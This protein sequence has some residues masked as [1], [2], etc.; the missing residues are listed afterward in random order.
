[1]ASQGLTGSRI[2]E[3]RLMRGIR[4]AELAREI[5]ISASYLNLIEH[6]RRRIGGKLLLDIAETLGVAP[7]MLIQGAEAALVAS[8]REAGDVAGLSSTEADRVEDFAGRFPGWAEALSTAHRRIAA[9][10][11]TIETLSDRM[12]HDPQLAASLYELLSTAAAIRS[13]AAILA[14]TKD[15]DQSQQERFHENM[16]QDSAR[17]SDS[18]KRLVQFLDA[19]PT[20]TIASSPTEEVETFLSANEYSF[21]ELEA[22]NI[23]IDALLETSERNMSTDAQKMTRAVLRRMVQDSKTLPTAKLRKAVIETGIDPMRLA[24]SL[25]VPLPL[26]LRRLANVPEYGLGLVVCDRSGS[27]IFRKP[28]EGF[29]IP[30]FGAACPLW[31]LFQALAM[32]GHILAREMTQLGRDSAVFDVFAM[33]EV[34]EDTQYNM[35]PLVYG[36]ML[37]CPSGSALTVPHGTSMEVVGPTCRVCPRAAC[38]ARREPSIL[39]ENVSV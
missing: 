2:R 15:L 36:S 25:S 5:G 11:R 26:V 38:N 34:V 31:P 16:D 18:A 19:E 29:N 22:G 35:P 9:L 24:Q 13:T 39:T 3:R 21:P 8:L 7:Q 20:E 23:G 6:N 10:E 30:R 32:P 17:L 1:M 12:A 27:L 14:E 4:Q 33:S 37:I 28:I